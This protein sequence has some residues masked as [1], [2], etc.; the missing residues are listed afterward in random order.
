M[1]SN[2]F[3]E[4]LRKYF[5]SS[6][7]LLFTVTLL[8]STTSDAFAYM[9]SG[10]F[11]LRMPTT[12]DGNIDKNGN[13]IID[14]N[15]LISQGLSN[16]AEEA[17][18]ET[19]ITASEPITYTLIVGDGYQPAADGSILAYTRLVGAKRDYESAYIHRAEI[20]TTGEITI[21]I[22]ISSN[23]IIDFAL[24]N[25]VTIW[26]LYRPKVEDN[27][28]IIA[29]EKYE[30]DIGWQIPVIFDDSS[31]V[32][33]ATAGTD[34]FLID[35]A[36]ENNQHIALYNT[37]ERE[38]S[39]PGEINVKVFN[40]EGE[41]LDDVFLFG[42]QGEDG[43]Y[44]A[45]K[46]EYN[47]HN[48]EYWLAAYLFTD[49]VVSSDTLYNEYRMKS[50]PQSLR[51]QN[52]ENLWNNPQ[53]EE[54]LMISLD[55]DSNPVQLR[56]LRYSPDWELIDESIIHDGWTDYL[57]TVDMAP[58]DDGMVLVYQKGNMWGSPYFQSFDNN[59]QPTS[60]AVRLDDLGSES[61]GGYTIDSWGDNNIFIFA[62]NAWYA[63]ANT[64]VLDDK[65]NV[66]S[67][68]KLKPTQEEAYG[69]YGPAIGVLNNEEAFVSFGTS[70]V[71]EDYPWFGKDEVQVLY[72][73]K[74]PEIEYNYT[75]LPL[76]VKNY[77]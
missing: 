28:N 39:S 33:T 51:N 76:V 35:L 20:T 48:G 9:M 68:Y 45:N 1:E 15:M 77:Q 43:Y 60:A 42:Q 19:P 23:T 72:F 57:G 30:D 50:L 8:I 56:L 61:C 14:R 6:C 13:A 63:G 12:S 32:I 3:K 73:T 40:E 16:E 65:G 5:L 59:G 38:G 17:K 27:G 24:D 64:L 4:T 69:S 18:E 29:Y 37:W 46:L 41:A 26:P 70:V 49:D 71:D 47:P 58:S 2:T 25:G 31:H 44:F 52:I 67:G 34:I 62:Y 75:Y 66:L 21:P 10:E 36:K 22:K 11:G 55:D 54:R 74:P 53:N 7:V